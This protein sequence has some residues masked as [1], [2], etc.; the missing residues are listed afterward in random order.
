MTSVIPEHKHPRSHCRFATCMHFH[1]PLFSILTKDG[2]KCFWVS[3]GINSLVSILYSHEGLDLHFPILSFSLWCTFSLSPFS[4]L[5]AKYSSLDITSFSPSSILNS[6]HSVLF[7]L[8]YSPF[9]CLALILI[10]FIVFDSQFWMHQRFLLFLFSIL[11]INLNSHSEKL[12]SLSLFSIL[13][14]DHQSLASIL[15]SHC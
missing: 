13:M 9:S 10:N 7:C 1:L 4:I 12:F 14:I 5:R 6:Q 15:Y 11:S 2:S 3:N 8:C